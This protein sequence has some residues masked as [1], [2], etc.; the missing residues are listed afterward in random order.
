MTTLKATR[1]DQAL[2]AE[3]APFGDDDQVWQDV[4]TRAIVV[5]PADSD[6]IPFPGGRSIDV[7]NVS[8]VR[9]QFAQV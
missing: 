3:L 6:V 9:E 7:G 8:D 5:L 1:I 2:V 4:K